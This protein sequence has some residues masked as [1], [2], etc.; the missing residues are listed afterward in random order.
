MNALYIYYFTFISRLSLIVYFCVRYFPFIFVTYLSFVR[1]CYFQLFFL[2]YLLSI[3]VSHLSFIFVLFSIH[4]FLTYVSLIFV[5]LTF[6]VFLCDLPF[7]I[8]CDLLFIHFHLHEGS[9]LY[10]SFIIS[11]IGG[12]EL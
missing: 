11:L 4:I 9:G 7:I 2:T 12:S 6:H 1:V 10:F 8:F 3:F 5:S